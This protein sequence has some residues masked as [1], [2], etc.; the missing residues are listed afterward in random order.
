MRA[1]SP[2]AEKAREL[3]A[4]TT[5]EGHRAGVRPSSGA[6]ASDLPSTLKSSETLLLADA[7][8]TTEGHRAGVRP[9]AN[10]SNSRSCTRGLVLAGVRAASRFRA[11]CCLIIEQDGKGPACHPYHPAIVWG[12][13]SKLKARHEA[14]LKTVLQHR[15]HSVQHISARFYQ[16]KV[17]RK[18][19]SCGCADHISLVS[20]GDQQIFR[21]PVPHDRIAIF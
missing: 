6:A 5:T 19:L 13:A 15:K 1:A 11:P 10:R 21:L 4:G 17:Y 3:L 7:G 8:T 2:S 14:C 9:E 18:Q 16:V 12:C 20:I